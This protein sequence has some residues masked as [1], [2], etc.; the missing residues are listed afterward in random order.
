MIYLITIFIS[1][2]A[3]SLE[4]EKL[5]QN[6]RTLSMISL[7]KLKDLESFNLLDS[8]IESNLKA[9]KFEMS[10]ED[11]DLNW[12]C[13]KLIYYLQKNKVLK[14]SQL[15]KMQENLNLSCRSFVLKKLIDLKKIKIYLSEFCYENLKEKMDILVYSSLDDTEQK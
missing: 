4:L 14:L 13:H 2:K 8:K 11:F 7:N 10:I 9:C 3:Y 6:Q 5:I 15:Q 1:F 12:S